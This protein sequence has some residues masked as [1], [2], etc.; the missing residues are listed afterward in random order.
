MLWSSSQLTAVHHITAEVKA[1]LT[2]SLQRVAAQAWL[3]GHVRTPG[4]LPLLR[5]FAFQRA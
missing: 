1:A 5:S 4:H 2:L 3:R